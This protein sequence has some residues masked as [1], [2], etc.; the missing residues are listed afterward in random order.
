M[1]YIALDKGKKVCYVTTNLILMKKSMFKSFAVMAVGIFAL[2][3][4][5]TTAITTKNI[6]AEGAKLAQVVLEDKSTTQN[7]SLCV[8]NSFVSS[9]YSVT[10]GD[11]SIKVYYGD[12]KGA[13]TCEKSKNDIRSVYEE[14]K[15]LTAGQTYTIT[16][17]G[18]AELTGAVNSSKIVLLDS[19]PTEPF[20]IVSWKSVP[21]ATGVCMDKFLY[22]EDAPGSKQAVV[23]HGNGRSFTFDYTANDVFCTPKSTNSNS[24]LKL[25]IKCGCDGARLYNLGIQ[26]AVDNTNLHYTGLKF[27]SKTVD[28]VK[29]TETPVV[30]VTPLPTP[31]VEE[32]TPT[33]EATPVAVPA[34]AQDT[35]AAP[36]VADLAAAQTVTVRS[37]GNSVLFIA[38]LIAGLAAF[39]YFATKTKKLSIN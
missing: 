38:P 19:T 22:T 32:P 34:K 13:T 30:D 8:N 28:A 12:L 14:T 16:V 17:K 6:F 20:S 18:A 11:V 10:P 9:P 23:I 15:S 7:L 37:G 33:T 2:G 36:V 1:G 24:N 29:E 31:T 5:V 4:L 27:F 21:N 26:G 3:F 39:A 35:P 25:D